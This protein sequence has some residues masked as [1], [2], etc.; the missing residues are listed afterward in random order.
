MTRDLLLYTTITCSYNLSLGFI[1]R[2]KKKVPIGHPYNLYLYNSRASRDRTGPIQQKGTSHGAIS[3]P[4]CW[5][6]C[7][8]AANVAPGVLNTSRW[9]LAGQLSE[10]FAAVFEGSLSYLLLGSLRFLTGERKIKVF[11]EMI[12]RFVD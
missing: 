8:I 5:C 11:E 4:T 3:R 1:V 10:T 9:Y 6:R 12:L 2:K 7:F